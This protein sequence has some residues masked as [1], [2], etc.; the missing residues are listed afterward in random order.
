MRVREIERRTGLSRKTIRKYRRSGVIQPKF[1]ILDRPRI[2][3]AFAWKLSIW[4]PDEASKGRKQRLT[5]IYELI[6]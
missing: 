6:P 3:D 4:L 5:T 1:K 2:L